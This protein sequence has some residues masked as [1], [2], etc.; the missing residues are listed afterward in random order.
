M[1]PNWSQ[2]IIHPRRLSCCD[3][4]PRFGRLYFFLSSN[5]NFTFLYS[6]FYMRTLVSFLFST[7]SRKHARA[8]AFVSVRAYAS[9]CICTYTSV[10]VCGPGLYYMSYRDGQRTASREPCG[11]CLNAYLPAKLYLEGSW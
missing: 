6:M 11:F 1:L 3:V 2:F 8:C 7:C 4:G 10:P 9:L 5:F